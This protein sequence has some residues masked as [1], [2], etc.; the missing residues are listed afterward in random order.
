MNDRAKT[1][2][3]LTATGSVD[4]GKSTLLGRLLYETESIYED[5]YEAVVKTSQR[6]GFEQPDLAWLLDGLSAE[7]QQGITID[8]AYRYFET[9]KNK[10]IIIDTP[11]HVQYTRNMVTGASQADCAIILIDAGNG[12]LTQSKRHGFLCPFYNSPFDC[13]RQ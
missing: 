9:Q 6:H 5:Q 10:Y 7:R 12:V 8:V 2:L 11:G 4:D 1:L 13:S 3:R